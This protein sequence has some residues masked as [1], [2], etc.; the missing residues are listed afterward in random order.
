MNV[1][2]GLDVRR[3]LSDA[4]LCAGDA[5]EEVLL[6]QGPGAVLLCWCSSVRASG[7]VSV[8]GRKRHVSMGNGLRATLR[9]LRLLRIVGVAMRERRRRR[10]RRLVILCCRVSSCCSSCAIAAAYASAIGVG[11]AV[12]TTSVRV[13]LSVAALGLSVRVAAVCLV[14]LRHVG[15]V[16]G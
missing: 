1:G 14:V 11:R 12:A 4:R 7:I 3:E 8:D 5:R 15:C 6:A 13:G 9:V 16:A 2:D 10:V